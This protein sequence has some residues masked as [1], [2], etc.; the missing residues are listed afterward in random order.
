MPLA[1]LLLRYYVYAC[2]RC[3]AVTLA[4]YATVV[5]FIFRYYYGA[6][7]CLAPAR[8]PPPDIDTLFAALR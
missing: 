8:L 4:P 3:T 6:D 2:F 1:M 5:A 7:Y